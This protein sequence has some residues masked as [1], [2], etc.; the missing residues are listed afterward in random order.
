MGKSSIGKWFHIRLCVV[1]LLWVSDCAF[2]GTLGEGIALTALTQDGKSAAV[3][4]AP[5]GNKIAYV[6]NDGD[7]EICM[8]NNDGSNPVLVT[9]NSIDDI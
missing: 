2:C 9:D 8:M 4:W 6:C 7:A 3:G 1:A 5:H